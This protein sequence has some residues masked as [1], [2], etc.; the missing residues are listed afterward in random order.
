[1]FRMVAIQLDR[2]P[3]MILGKDGAFLDYAAGGDVTCVTHGHL[4]HVGGTHNLPIMTRETYHILRARNV[5]ISNYVDARRDQTIPLAEDLKMTPMNSGHM[6]GSILFKIDTPR[7]DIVYTGDLNTVETILERPA[8]VA[9]C[10][11]LIIEATYGAPIYKFGP[12]E[13]IYADI[14]RWVLETLREGFIPCFKVYTA[15]KAQEIIGLIN[16]LLNIEVLVSQDVYRVSM[17]YKQSYPWM[18]FELLGTVESREIMRGGEFVYVTNSTR[19]R[20]L[21]GRRTKWAVATGWALSNPF[22]EFDAAFPLS[23][24][25]DFK[26]L[27]EYVE[28]ASPN[29]IFTMYGHSVTFAKFLRKLGYNAYAL[30]EK[31]R[32]Q[33]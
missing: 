32:H 6:L 30:E 27:V 1:M 23:S 19:Q 20:V 26:G 7:G 24:H 28:S 3:T 4:D 13:S 15:G 10:E 31:T 12:R 21:E 5:R 29:K 18:S 17:V 16:S 11:D 22:P 33:L 25:A 2:G 14:A 8:E 9:T